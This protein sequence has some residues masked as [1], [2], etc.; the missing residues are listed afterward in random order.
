MN[1][2]G[3]HWQTLFAQIR[4]MGYPLERVTYSQWRDRLQQSLPKENPLYT[5]LPFL[6]KQRTDLQL[7][8][9]ELYQQQNACKF[10]CHQ[11][12]QTLVADNLRCPPLDRDLLKTYFSYFVQTGYLQNGKSLKLTK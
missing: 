10:D 4:Q 9:L 2:L 1:P 11:T 5:L 7:T 3:M 12:V 8:A 6:L